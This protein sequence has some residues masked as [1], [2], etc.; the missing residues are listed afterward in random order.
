MLIYTKIIIKHSASL[1]GFIKN[2][3]LSFDCPQ[4]WWI[5]IF[6]YRPTATG[7]MQSI[8]LISIYHPHSRRITKSVKLISTCD[9]EAYVLPKVNHMLMTSETKPNKTLYAINDKSVNDHRIGSV[10]TRWQIYEITNIEQF[11]APKTHYIEKF[12]KHLAI[13]YF[14]QR[15]ANA[16]AWYRHFRV[17]LCYLIYGEPEI[18][19]NDLYPPKFVAI[20]L[21]QNISAINAACCIIN[22]NN[23]SFINYL[24]VKSLVNNKNRYKRDASFWIR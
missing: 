16:L 5:L 13:V 20:Y 6:Q 23:T 1:P 14:K 8:W 7:P 12:C 18:K 21:Q 15:V 3:Q 2:G 24:Y 10:T 4:R 11:H 19:T 22:N 17:I 9:L